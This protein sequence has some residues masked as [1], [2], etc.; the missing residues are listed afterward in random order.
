MTTPQSDLDVALA[1]ARAGAEVLD[2]MFGSDLTRVHKTATDFATAADR[3]A[4]RA[5]LDVIQAA[6]PEDGFEGEELGAVHAGRDAGRGW[7]TR[8]AGR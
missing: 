3:A 8:S 5:I 6:R 1:A 4:E 7:S 2:T